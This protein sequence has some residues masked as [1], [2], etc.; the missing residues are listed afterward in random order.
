ME[1]IPRSKVTIN[2]AVSIII[3][4]PPKGDTPYRIEVMVVRYLYFHFQKRE[5]LKNEW[6][7]IGMS[8]MLT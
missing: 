8:K 1:T 4:V 7:K 6:D 2:I 5:V 3:R